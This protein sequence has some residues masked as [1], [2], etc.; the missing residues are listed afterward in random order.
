VN[1]HGA[2]GLRSADLDPDPFGLL[3]VWFADTR[4]AGIVFPGAMALATA[5]ARS[6]GDDIPGPP[7][8]G[9][10]GSFGRRRVLEG[11]RSRLHHRSGYERQP[12]GT[13]RIER[14]YT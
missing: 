5:D 7:H 4:D 2:E 3:R 14:L 13:W 10:R 9:A 12:D 1:G 6:P 11:R 8:F